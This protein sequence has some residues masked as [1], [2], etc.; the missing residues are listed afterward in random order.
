MSE[1]CKCNHHKSEHKT[2]DEDD[3]MMYCTICGC[4]EYRENNTN[5]TKLDNFHS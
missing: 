1:Y 5:K 3:S 4:D 2:Y